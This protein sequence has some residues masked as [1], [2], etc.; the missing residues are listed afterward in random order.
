M[1][2]YTI[3]LSTSYKFLDKTFISRLSTL[4]WHII[5]KVGLNYK[6][7]TL[8]RLSS[9]SLLAF[10]TNCKKDFLLKRIFWCVGDQMSIS[11]SQVVYSK[12][13]HPFN[14]NV[15]SSADP[16]LGRKTSE[17]FRGPSCW[18]EKLKFWFWYIGYKQS[19]EMRGVIEQV[20][21]FTC[22]KSRMIV[23]EREWTSPI[24]WYDSFC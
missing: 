23:E 13:I 16:L 5:K 9:L 24:S 8:W 14:S 22:S 6:Y 20:V 11:M 4:L 10:N 19:G 17:F 1:T 2:F 15:C 12:L 21:R 7:W 18:N 3:L